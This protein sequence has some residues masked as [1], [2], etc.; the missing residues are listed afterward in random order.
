MV[1]M[2]STKVTTCKLQLPTCSLIVLYEISTGSLEC[3]HVG[4]NQLPKSET[5]KTSANINDS[6]PRYYKFFSRF[7]NILPLFKPPKV[8]PPTFNNFVTF[9]TGP[10]CFGCCS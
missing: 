4:S 9:K 2:D 10:L 1:I 7:I 5:R 3:L 8:C 6:G